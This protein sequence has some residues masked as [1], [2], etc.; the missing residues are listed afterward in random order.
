M[1]FSSNPKWNPDGQHCYITGGSSGLGLSLAILLVRKG[2]HVSI[3]ARNQ[4]RL[5]KALAELEAVRQTPNQTL[6]A[7]SYSLDTAKES[8]KALEAACEPF[9]GVAPDAIFAVA[10]SSKPMFFVEMQE[11]DLIEGFVN[12]YWVQAWTAFAATK[13]MVKQ[14]RKGKLVLVSS[15]M[16]YFTYIGWANYSPAKQAL[17]GLGDS[18]QQELLLYDISVHTF[19]PPAMLTPGYEEENK[20]KP[21]ITMKIEEDDKGI[22]TEAAADILFSGVVNGQAHITCDI[23]GHV[24]RASTRG[25]TP[26]NS[27]IKDLLF[28]MVAFVGIPLWKWSVDRTVLAHRGEHER[29][30]IQKGFLS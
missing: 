14:K 29:Y 1:F 15:I 26:R 8:A 6:K 18:L 5:D 12:G 2:A 21:A 16:G 13:M 3:V 10:G 17:R 25:A 23:I 22:S 19:F 30:L 28:D 7:Y 9:G 27:W 20:T 11:E 4:E 24:F